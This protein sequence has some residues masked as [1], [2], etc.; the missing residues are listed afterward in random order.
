VIENV[1]RYDSRM[2]YHKPRIAWSVGCGII[3][4]PLIALC[5]SGYDGPE[6]DWIQPYSKY[7]FETVSDH[8]HFAFRIVD[9]SA[10]PSSVRPW[11]TFIGEGRHEMTFVGDET[12]PRFRVKVDGPSL[13]VDMPGY[14]PVLLSAALSAA[15]WIPRRFSLRTLLI[16]MTLIAAGL[17][18]IV[19]FK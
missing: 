12:R 18:L 7:G 15:P 11:R 4:L 9:T 3:C 13:V 1:V 19:V 14:L 8:G 17:G 6:Y 10:P 5:G 2:K 16:A